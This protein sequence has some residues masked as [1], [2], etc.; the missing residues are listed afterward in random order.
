MGHGLR[1]WRVCGCLAA[2]IGAA[3]AIAQRRPTVKLELSIG[4]DRFLLGESISVD[5]RLE[6]TGAQAVERQ[7]SRMFKTRSRCIV[8]RGLPIRKASVSACAT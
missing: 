8:L 3:L 5:I 7:N 4:R 1:F 2:L 6:N